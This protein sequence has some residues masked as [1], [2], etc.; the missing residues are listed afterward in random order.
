LKVFAARTAGAN[1]EPA[2]SAAP[3]AADV[4]RTA[5]R[6][7]QKVPDVFT[8]ESSLHP[9][10]PP[11]TPKTAQVFVERSAVCIQVCSAHLQK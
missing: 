3:V 10:V 9:A 1:T 7:M 4:L 8:I 2:A 5:R 11:F 6:L